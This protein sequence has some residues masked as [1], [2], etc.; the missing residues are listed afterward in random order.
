[1]VDGTAQFP[2]VVARQ[3]PGLSQVFRD[4]GFI[5]PGFLSVFFIFNTYQLQNLSW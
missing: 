3:F 4:S 1:M 5:R 2:D